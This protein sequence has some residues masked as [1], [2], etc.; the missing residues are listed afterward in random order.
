MRL[1]RSRKGLTLIEVVVSTAI[2]SVV[3]VALF[4][5]ANSTMRGLMSGSSKDALANSATLGL[6]KICDEIRDGKTASVSA[7]GK[8]LTVRFPVLLTDTSTNE[9]IYDSSTTDPTP[10]IYYVSDGNL[11]K[12]VSGRVS[13]V[14]RAVTSATFHISLSTVDITLS[15]TS[16][17]ADQSFT[18]SSQGQVTLRNYRGS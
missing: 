18:Q 4:S 13:I 12:S 2:L 9:R 10:R 11:V 14:Q 17:Y 3:A 7:D 16:G 1:M 8:V 5:V 15:S 6:Q